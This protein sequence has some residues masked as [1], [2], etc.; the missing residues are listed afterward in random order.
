MAYLT[1]A[2]LLLLA[3][4]LIRPNW[5]LRTQWAILSTVLVFAVG[6]LLLFDI[7]I[8]SGAVGGPQSAISKGAPSVNTCVVCKE[9]FLFLLMLAGMMAKGLYDGLGQKENAPFDKRR[10]LRP[11]LVSPIVFGTV[12][13]GIGEYA[14]SSMLLWIFAFQNGFFWQTVL[15]QRVAA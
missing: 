10:I 5:N 1:L 4:F 11:L 8:K 15:D 3:T 12:Y 13:G 9:I 7:I 2:L 14:A 6:G